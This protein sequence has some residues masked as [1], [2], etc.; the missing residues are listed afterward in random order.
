MSKDENIKSLLISML[1]TVADAASDMEV[2]NTEC[3]KLYSPVFRY[4]PVF[5]FSKE[6]MRTIKLLAK[7]ELEDFS[8]LTDS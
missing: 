1:R 6:D 8:T 3:G 5:E 2:E 7:E 4:L